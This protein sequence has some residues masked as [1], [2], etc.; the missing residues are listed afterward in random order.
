MGRKTPIA[1]LF[2]CLMVITMPAGSQETTLRGSFISMAE[3]IYIAENALGPNSHAI[4]AELSGDEWEIDL[5]HG[6]DL[7]TYWIDTSSGDVTD[8]GEQAEVAEFFALGATL[9]PAQTALTL[10]EAVLKAQALVGGE[11][12]E[13]ELD[14]GITRNRFDIELVRQ[15]DYV[16]VEINPQTGQIAQVEE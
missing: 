7:Y 16:D 6:E 4:K 5:H 10:R 8:A 11:P 1:A 2:A 13:A 12:V 15:G 9:D 3:A 14:S